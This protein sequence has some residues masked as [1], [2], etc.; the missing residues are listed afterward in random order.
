MKKGNF[1]LF[2]LIIIKAKI[3]ETNPAEMVFVLEVGVVD[4]SSK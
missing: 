3:T 2:S 4:F 1:F